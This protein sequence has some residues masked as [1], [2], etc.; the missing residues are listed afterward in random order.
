M[1]PQHFGPMRWDRKESNLLRTEQKSG[2]RRYTSIPFSFRLVLRLRLRFMDTPR[3]IDHD[4]ET[5][6]SCRANACPR[7]TIR[8]ERPHAS[9][10]RFALS[11]F[12]LFEQSSSGP[13]WS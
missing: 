11:A 4:R 8:V 1:P 2:M 13:V 5:H 10:T 9:S 7:H 12:A 3:I 6:L